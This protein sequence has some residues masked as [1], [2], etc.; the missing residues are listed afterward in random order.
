MG[1]WGGWALAPD[2]A[3]GSDFRSHMYWS[4]DAPHPF[5]VAAI[6]FNLFAPDFWSVKPV[7]PPAETASQRRFSDAVDGTCGSKGRTGGFSCRSAVLSGASSRDT[8]RAGAVELASGAI[9]A[10]TAA[11]ASASPAPNWSSR[12]GEP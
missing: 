7:A 1:A 11:N 10:S 12:P 2:I 8:S 4:W 5:N 6:F 3:M 9:T